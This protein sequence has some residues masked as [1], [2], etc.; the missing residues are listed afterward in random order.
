MASATPTRLQCAAS[1]DVAGWTLAVFTGSEPAGVGLLVAATVGL[2]WQWRSRRT[3]KRRAAEL[4]A[5]E[6]RQRRII[7]GATDGIVITDGETG[8]LLQANRAVAELLGL[9]PG[10][11]VGRHHSSFYPPEKRE[12]MERRFRGRMLRGGLGVAEVWVHRGSGELI[13]VGLHATPIELDGRRQ[14]QAT[15]LDLRQ[16]HIAQAALRES[17]ARFRALF[18]NAPVAVMEKDY[19]QVV[20]W[21]EELR[22]GGLVDLRGHLQEHPEALTAQFARARVTAANRT[23]LQRLG[24]PD[25]ATYNRVMTERIPPLVLRSFQRELEA[26]WVGRTTMT[27]ALDYVRSEGRMGHSLLHWSVPMLDGRPDWH[28]VLL[29]FTDLT[30]LRTAEE[31]L[32]A[33]EEQSRLALRGFNVGIWEYKFATNESFYSERWKQMLGYGPQEIGGRREEWLARGIRRT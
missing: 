9:S 8:I 3:W 26:L 22:T 29:V 14:M 5:A 1:G 17:E 16:E 18:E 6:V 7:D 24:L 10:E 32:R 13:P 28:R 11:M 20:G 23:A 27:C 15:V 31:R 25:V 12:E 21:M 2:I 33:S 30:E 4:A 19:T